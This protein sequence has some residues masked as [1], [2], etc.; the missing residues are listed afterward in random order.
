MVTN[1]LPASGRL[2]RVAPPAPK[3]GILR[4]RELLRELLRRDLQSRHKGSA[5]GNLWSLLNP[6]L[7]MLVYTAVFSKFVRFPTGGPPYPV[8]LLSALL[9][10]NFFAQAI[11][12]SCNSVLDNGSLVKKVHFPWVLLTVSSVIA[13]FINYLIG[14]ILLV[15]LLLYY[16]ATGAHVG[17]GIP[18]LIAPVLA[19]LTF[20]FAL[21]LGLILAAANV[22]FRDVQYMLAIVL[23]VWFFLTPIIYPLSVADSVPKPGHGVADRSLHIFHW[24]VY[25]N[26]V[27]W[28]ATSF[29]DVIAFHRWPTHQL[30][31]AY[32]T[33]V[34]VLLLLTGVLVFN[35]FSGRFAE[36]L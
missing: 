6:L 34:A 2:G 16:Y 1:E 18:L 29:Q 3:R 27:T 15:P 14:L 10:W 19:V 28:I 21:G 12:Y 23:Q 32:S 11:S 9:A 26:P 13:A 8:Y 30:G 31:L 25:L 24:V 17:V 35:R 7:Y 36:E 22:Y 20:A 33:S 4:H 5:L